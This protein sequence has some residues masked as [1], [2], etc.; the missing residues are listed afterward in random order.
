MVDLVAIQAE[1]IAWSEKNFG[2][3]HERYPLM[4]MIE[5]ILEFDAA[6]KAR[7]KAREFDMPSS[8]GLAE[9]EAEVVDAIGDIAIYMLD[10]CG[11]RGLQLK[12]L[13]DLRAFLDENMA[14]VWWD[15][16][17]LARRLAHHQLKG[18]QGIRGSL[19]QHQE[20]ID[21]TCCAI[22]AHL[23]VSCSYLNQDPLKIIDKVWSKVKQRDWTKNPINAHAVAEAT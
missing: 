5:E 1:Q 9:L 8:K 3:Q 12:T 22:L 15:L 17:P 2:K 16:A 10:Y 14:I 13:W 21:K 11:K 7:A 20:E 4:G 23:D 18:E 19:A 6:W